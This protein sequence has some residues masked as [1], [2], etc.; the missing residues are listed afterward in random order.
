L[1]F[2]QKDSDCEVSQMQKIW[3]DLPAFSPQAAAAGDPL[4]VISLKGWRLKEPVSGRRYTVLRVET[5]GGTVGYGEG[6]PARAHE[7][8][9]ARA[10]ATGRRV[11]ESEFIRHSLAACPAMEAAVD[12]A[13]LDVLGKSSKVPIYQYLGGPT[14]YKARVA[15]HLEVRDANSVE[16]PL[17]RAAAQGFRA[18]T[19]PLLPRD[20]MTRIQSYV[21][22]LRQWVERLRTMAGENAD[23]IL[24]AAGTLTPG[25]ASSIAT[26]LERL[27]LLWIDEP[28]A[29][30]SNDALEKVTAESVTPIGL[31]RN[32]SDPAVF[33]NLL[34]WQCVDV[35]RPSLGLN[36]TPKIR[37]IAAIAE[38]NY[39]AVAPY[40]DGGPVG[41]VAAIHMAATA[42]NFFLQQVPQPLAEQDRAMRA[43]LTSGNVETAKD[44]FAMLI[45]RPGLGIEVNEQALNKYSE[46]TV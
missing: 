35:L 26:A 10:A 33:Q 19:I 13:F 21:D 14:R 2:I 7:I 12:N 38:A 40:H 29:V 3:K 41:T 18:F 5:R 27:H 32:V 1:R 8:A 15:A 25:D 22:Q 43:E 31:G 17:R 46:E 42:P 45:N 9:E 44:G 28:T 6:G 11:T 24:D 37:R 30:L 20:P 34:R 39:V 36:G 16:E 4:A 23:F